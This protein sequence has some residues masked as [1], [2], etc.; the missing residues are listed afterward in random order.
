[1]VAQFSSR[2]GIYI[3]PENRGTMQQ[4]GNITQLLF[5]APNLPD[6]DLGLCA[7]LREVFQ[8]TSHLLCL[9]H[10]NRDVEAKV[11]K[12]FG[13]KTVGVR[14]RAGRWFKIVNA[15]TQAEY[16]RAL[17]AMQVRWGKYPEVIQYVQRTW[18]CHKEKFVKFWT[19]QVLHFGNTTN[20]R[21]ESQHSA[22]K[23]WFESSTESLA[24]ALDTVWARVHC[25]ISN[26]IIQ[27][28]NDL[29]ASRS[30]IQ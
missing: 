3:I 24:S 12:M 20:C 23:T 16:D 1:M 6:R 26:H 28:R 4:Q 19:N 7:A 11:T 17:T 2:S 18:L 25:H 5:V 22:V 15:T 8:G 14:F 9:C 27:I 30:K 13:N 21:V 10:I 29:E